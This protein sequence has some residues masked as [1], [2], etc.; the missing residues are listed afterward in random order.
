MLTYSMSAIFSTIVNYRMYGFQG[1]SFCN[2]KLFEKKYPHF[3]DE[4]GDKYIISSDFIS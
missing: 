1:L 3:L 4:Y 2:C